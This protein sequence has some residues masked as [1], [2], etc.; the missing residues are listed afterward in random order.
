MSI[1]SRG[2][3]IITRPR[4]DAFIV[5]FEN[6]SHLFSSVSFVG[7]KLVNVS[8]VVARGCLFHIFILAVPETLGGIKSP[9]RPFHS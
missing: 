8:W 1:A 2:H 4:S 9:L 6:I 5:S 3:S 7:L